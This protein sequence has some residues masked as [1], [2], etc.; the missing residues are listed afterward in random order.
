VI[1]KIAA[2]VLG[3]F[4][5]LCLQYHW[6]L[7]IARSIYT[8]THGSANLVRWDKLYV[9]VTRILEALCPLQFVSVL[10]A[11][12]QIYNAHSKPFKFIIGIESVKK[13]HYFCEKRAR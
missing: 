13:L 1:S 4:N 11:E 7:S 6:K 3:K 8:C 9:F 2:G 5:V 12:L 10:S